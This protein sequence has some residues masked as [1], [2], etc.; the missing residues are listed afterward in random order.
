MNHIPENNLWMLFHDMVAR[1]LL[2]SNEGPNEIALFVLFSKLSVCNKVISGELSLREAYNNLQGELDLLSDD[3]FQPVLEQTLIH[4]LYS[5]ARLPDH[6]SAQHVTQLLRAIQELDARIHGQWSH[7][8]WQWAGEVLGKAGDASIMP[9]ELV[10]LISGI[11]LQEETPDEVYT[12]FLSSGQLAS[13]AA[14]KAGS[15]FHESH[16]ISPLSFVCAVL[17]GYQVSGTN[18]I[19]SPAYTEDGI[20]KQFSHVMMNPPFNWKIH[21]Q[22]H[23]IYGRFTHPVKGGDVMVLQHALAQCSGRMVSLLPMGFLFRGGVDRD[24]RRS[25]LESGWVD[26]VIQLPGQ[27]LTNTS[28]ATCI[29]V[30]DKNRDPLAPVYFYNADSE[31]LVVHQGRGRGR[32]IT[33]WQTILSDVEAKTRHKRA[34][35]ASLEEIADNNYDLSVS[36]YVLTGSSHAMRDL[37]GKGNTNPLSSVATLIRAQILKEADSQLSNEFLE[38]RLS[39]IAATGEVQRPEKALKLAGKTQ[40][41]AHQQTVQPG[42]ILLSIKGVTGRTAFV[43]SACEENWVAGQIFLIIRPSKAIAPLYLYR[44]LSSPIVQTYLSDQGSGSTIKVI[45]T[46]DLK[47]LP[48]PL[49]SEEEKQQVLETHEHIQQAYQVIEQAEQQIQELSHQHWALPAAD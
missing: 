27:L 19:H 26:A 32:K 36:R 25:L 8:L 13:V 23:D 40:D 35:L 41:R 3:H 44:Y 29:L 20:L 10:L 22:V 31:D 28:L 43:S 21:D 30:I 47:N 42:D 5:K 39:D 46:D 15:V 14:N 24:L 11:C 37:M 38:I 34:N 6:F 1:S 2:S 7:T 4:E 17:D 33:G 49:P 48:V 9:E 12:P 16:Y 45:K 18:P